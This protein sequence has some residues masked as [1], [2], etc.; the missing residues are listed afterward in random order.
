MNSCNSLNL[1]LKEDHL[2]VGEKLADDLAHVV[3]V[4]HGKEQVK[5][6]AADGDV[7]V[8][9]AV[10]YALPMPDIA[11]TKFLRKLHNQ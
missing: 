1:S 5:R 3:G 10:Y 9:Q 7:C 4:A 8:L 11:K 6:A 2:E